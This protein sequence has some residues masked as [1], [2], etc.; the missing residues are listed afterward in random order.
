MGLMCA[1][2]AMFLL[3]IHLPKRPKIEEGQGNQI[4][5]EG[6]VL[7]LE[8]M[9]QLVENDEASL[10]MYL[11]AEL[12]VP[13]YH[14]LDSSLRKKRCVPS[15]D[16]DHSRPVRGAMRHQLRPATAGPSLLKGRR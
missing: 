1:L 11:L 10:S 15:R 7:S 2:Q 12:E 3:A 5:M 9:P 16:L 8:A 14:P 6:Q 4:S 13:G